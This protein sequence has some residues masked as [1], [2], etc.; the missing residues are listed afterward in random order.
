M[1]SPDSLYSLQRNIARIRC[2]HHAPTLAL[3]LPYTAHV[4]LTQ[5]FRV[6]QTTAACTHDC[7]LHA[8]RA[9]RHQ[10]PGH[11]PLRSPVSRVSQS[12]RSCPRSSQVPVGFRKHS[13]HNQCN[14]QCAPLRSSCTIDGP[15]SI[16]APRVI[17]RTSGVIL[18]FSS[19]STTVPR[20]L[21]QRRASTSSPQHKR[22]IGASEVSLTAQEEHHQRIASM[23]TPP[24]STAASLGASSSPRAR[25][26]RD[27]L[28][29]GWRS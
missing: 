10:R 4:R 19:E 16:D 20:H 3:K 23:P 24:P 12:P 13:M 6:R 5:K 1:S 11:R 8:C 21:H 26:W 28:R 29:G 22:T 2:R 14:D 25:P 27:V 17:Q 18:N 15:R 7:M 9:N